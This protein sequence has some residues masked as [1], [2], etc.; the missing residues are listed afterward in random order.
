M[1][2]GG[3]GAELAPIPLRAVSPVNALALRPNAQSLALAQQPSQARQVLLVM[4]AQA[5]HQG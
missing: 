1:T 4:T 3:I 2:N 5:V